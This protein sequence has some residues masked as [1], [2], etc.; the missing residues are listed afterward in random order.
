MLVAGVAAVVLVLGS[1]M[2]LRMSPRKPIIA[3]GGGYEEGGSSYWYP[4]WSDNAE[5]AKE[6]IYGTGA[7]GTCLISN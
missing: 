3:I 5:M 4:Q 6:R 2:L 7:P 1:V